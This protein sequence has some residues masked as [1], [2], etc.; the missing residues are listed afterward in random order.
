MGLA[1]ASGCR[2][3]IDEGGEARENVERHIVRVLA[4]QGHTMLVTSRPAG[5]K[6]EMFQDHF[7]R[8]QLDI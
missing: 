3:G 8:L 7:H 6:A 4:P 1:F 5:L 2:A